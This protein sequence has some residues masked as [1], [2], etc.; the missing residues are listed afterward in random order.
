VPTVVTRSEYFKSATI[1]G[2]IAIGPGLHT[3]S[4]WQPALRP[5]PDPR[6]LVTLDDL[7]GWCAQMDT[8]SQFN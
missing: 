3:R 7:Q 2:A 6:A 5:D 4:G 8:V 1:E